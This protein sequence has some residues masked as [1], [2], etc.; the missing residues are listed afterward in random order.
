M[1]EN[2]ITPDTDILNML[3]QLPE[4]DLR[5]L[6]PEEF[7]EITQEQILMMLKEKETALDKFADPFK[8]L[9]MGYMSAD[10]AGLV[11]NF[12][13]ESLQKANEI[14]SALKTY[15]INREIAIKN[16]P[17]ALKQG[18]PV[19]LRSEKDISS[20]NVSIEGFPEYLTKP[21]E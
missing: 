7:E 15:G 12:R 13:R 20:G 21:M 17:Q 9:G 3:K 4:D 11:E 16:Y 1:T 2:T 19:S 6:T 10:Q 8:Y 14:D 5:A 18:M